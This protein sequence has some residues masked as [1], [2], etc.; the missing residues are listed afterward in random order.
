MW[1][2]IRISFSEYARQRGLRRWI[3]PVPVLTPRV[4]SLCLGLVTPLFARI[5]RKLVEGL[6]NQTIV[7]DNRAL[8]EFSVRPKSMKEA[9]ARA[10][11]NEDMEYAETRWM[12]ALSSKGML[13]RMD[14]SKL[15][16]RLVERLSEKAACPPEIAF[17]V[18]QRIGGDQ[19]WYYAD[20]SMAPAGVH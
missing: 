18:I 1:S 3:L 11:I 2:P 7:E 14:T 17:D 9:S 20:I 10:L 15:G 4:S 8:A 6:Q 13:R 19:G 16:P 12:G 5:G